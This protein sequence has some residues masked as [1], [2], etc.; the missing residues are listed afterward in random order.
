M[1][2]STRRLGLRSSS[3]D[4]R[5][6]SISRAGWFLLR[7]G[8]PGFL[9]ELVGLPLSLIGLGSFL[10]HAASLPHGEFRRYPEEVRLRPTTQQ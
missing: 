1:N 2:P 5:S 6:D 9:F 4:P 8:M 10:C 3:R 7:C